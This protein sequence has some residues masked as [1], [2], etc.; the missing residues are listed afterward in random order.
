[1]GDAAD[2]IKGLPGIGAKRA[3]AILLNKSSMTWDLTTLRA[4]V[5]HLGVKEGVE[6][7][8]KTANLVYLHRKPGDVYEFPCPEYINDFKQKITNI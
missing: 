3:S 4:Y 1:M 5:A 7:F 2:N 6:E 8:E